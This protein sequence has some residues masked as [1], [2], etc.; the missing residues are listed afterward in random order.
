M[1]SVSVAHN[2]GEYSK[3]QLFKKALM[4]YPDFIF[5]YPFFYP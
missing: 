1:V 5:F 3:T 2:V 4:I